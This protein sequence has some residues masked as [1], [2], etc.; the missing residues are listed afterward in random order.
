MGSGPKPAPR[1]VRHWASRDSAPLEVKLRKEK[2]CWPRR[3]L[4]T[5][6]K[7]TLS[8]Q[9]ERIQYDEE[10]NMF[11]SLFNIDCEYFFLYRFHESDYKKLAFPGIVGF[12][13]HT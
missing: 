1:P 13:L 7:K 2:P 5:R 9:F 4:S 11:F 8:S 6:N 10:T 3:N 12:Q